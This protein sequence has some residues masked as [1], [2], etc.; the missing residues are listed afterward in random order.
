MRLIVAALALMAVT[1]AGATEWQ[2]GEVEDEGGPVM[3][4]SVSAFEGVE[5]PELRLFCE[6][7]EVNLRYAFGSDLA[8]GADLPTEQPVDFT[9]TT[10]KGKATLPL[11]F[12]EMD[13]AYAASVS[14]KSTIIALL[15]GG[16][17]LTVDDPT[18]QYHPVSFPLTGSGKAIAA[19]LAT[20]P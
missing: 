19:L 12:E 11:Q 9:F 2:S 8:E 1:S 5:S 16:K 17:T 3:S 18:G 13:G 20:C 6:G 4:A 7:Q 14:A 15:K 10:D